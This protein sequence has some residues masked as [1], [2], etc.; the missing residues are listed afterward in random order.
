MRKFPGKTEY[1]AL[2]L[3]CDKKW[4]TNNAMAVG[5]KHAKKYRHNVTVET[6]LVYNY[7]YRESITPE[8]KN[9]EKEHND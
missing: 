6:T 8:E 3:T 7:F 5:A 9:N 4:Y 1:L 2:C